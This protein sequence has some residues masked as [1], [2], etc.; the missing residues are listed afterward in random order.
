VRKIFFITFAAF[1][2]AATVTAQPER[3]GAGLTFATKKRFNGGDTGNP[4][5]NIRTWI[6][7]DKKMIFH[8]MPSVTVFNLLDVNHTTHLTTTY[9][10]HGDLDLQA[11]L[12]HEQTL[13][14]VAIAGMNYTHIISRNDIY[15]TT[16]TD[17]PVDS[18]YYGFGPS[19]GAALEMRMAPQWDFIVTAKYSFAGLARGDAG[20]GEPFLVAPLSAPIIQVHGVY[21]FK[22]RGRGYMRR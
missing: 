14:L 21:Y 1:I 6:P 2:T 10:F 11:R 3:I 8:V 20:A 15:I 5:L 9:M 12:L 7:L 4:G 19:V 13:K 18:V 17:P 22:S 16:M